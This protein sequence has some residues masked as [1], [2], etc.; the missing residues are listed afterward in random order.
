MKLLDFAL[1]GFDDTGTADK[2]APPVIDLDV[3]S[4][5]NGNC[6][7]QGC[8]LVRHC[9]VQIVAAMVKLSQ[10]PKVLLQKFDS[11]E[12]KYAN[13]IGFSVKISSFRRSVVD[14]HKI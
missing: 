13:H 7:R 11:P 3:N 10:R 5:H 9:L 14:N 2:S 8:Q 4:E 12:N 1:V 6:G